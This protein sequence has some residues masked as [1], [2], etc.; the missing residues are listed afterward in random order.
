MTPINSQHLE[1]KQTSPAIASKFAD[2]L[3]AMNTHRLPG[4]LSGNCARGPRLKRHEDL[5][6]YN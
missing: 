4:Y 3:G 2:R 5:F 6:G 1:E